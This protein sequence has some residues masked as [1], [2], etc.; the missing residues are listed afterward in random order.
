MQ[1]ETIKLGKR[2]TL[3]IPAPVRQSY[4]LKEG[5]LVTVEARPEGLLIRPVVAFP[6]EQYSLEEKAR[7]LLSNTVTKEDLAWA[8]QE[9]RKMGLDPDKLSAKKTTR[10]GPKE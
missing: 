6:I 3:V 9:V 4:G 1:R 10:H 5:A 8:V 2:G 7:F